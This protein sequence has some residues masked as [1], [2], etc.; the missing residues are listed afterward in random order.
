[1]LQAFRT[2]DSVNLTFRLYTIKSLTESSDSGSATF[3]VSVSNC[4]EY[5]RGFLNCGEFT[6]CA[7]CY[8]GLT[9]LTGVVGGVCTDVCICVCMFF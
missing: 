7:F 3:T 2:S 6:G 9:I 8:C 5:I 4:G 1:M